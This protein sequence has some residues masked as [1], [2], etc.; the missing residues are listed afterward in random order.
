M[1]RGPAGERPVSNRSWAEHKNPARRLQ[2]EDDFALALIV[3]SMPGMGTVTFGATTSFSR[4]TKLL[5]Q[6]ASKER[7]SLL[8]SSAALVPC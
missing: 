6:F 7:Y 3:K 5:A 8:L 1:N 2:A 4:A